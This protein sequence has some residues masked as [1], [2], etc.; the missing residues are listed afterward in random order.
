MRTNQTGTIINNI[1]AI[2]NSVAF[3]DFI[4]I[5]DEDDAIIQIRKSEIIKMYNFMMAEQSKPT[6]PKLDNDKLFFKN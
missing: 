6:Q 1:K 4:A 2:D 3:A 5:L